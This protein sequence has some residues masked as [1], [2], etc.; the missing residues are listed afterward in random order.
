[1]GIFD[2][3]AAAVGRR[4][5]VA[6][7]LLTVASIFHVASGGSHNTAS[8][9]SSHSNPWSKD[10]VAEKAEGSP[11]AVSGSTTY[12]GSNKDSELKRDEEFR[13]QRVHEMREEY[14]ARHVDSPQGTD[15]D[16]AR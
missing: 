4:I 14:E 15:P 11:Y 10:Y 12:S 16:P 1:M 6:A 7:G 5:V 9:G 13:R 3:I 2:A 8:E